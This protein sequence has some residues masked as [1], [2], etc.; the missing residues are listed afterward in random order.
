MKFLVFHKYIN[1]N[2]NK[3]QKW[4]G[5]Q[6]YYLSFHRYITSGSI[7]KCISTTASG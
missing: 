7:R 2:D 3:I 1:M 5:Y 6:K 4:Y